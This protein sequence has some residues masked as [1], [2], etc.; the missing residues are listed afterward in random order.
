MNST[1]RCAWSGAV[2]AV[3]LS[4]C[5]PAQP[6]DTVASLTA[7]PARL[8]EVRRL[9]RDAREK[10]TDDLCLRAAEAAKHRFFGDR[11][12]QSDQ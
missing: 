8:K 7:D 4:A 12:E 10:I 6:D 3:L 5:G 11:P 1:I 2:L 9:C